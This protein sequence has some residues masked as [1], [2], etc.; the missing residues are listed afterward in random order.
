MMTRILTISCILLAIATFAA[1]TINHDVTVQSTAPQLI[2]P[3]DEFMVRVSI[4]KGALKKGAVLQQ[5]IPD[6]LSASEIESEGA[7][8]YFENQMVRFVW[9]NIPTKSML[10]VSYK[11]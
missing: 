3:G 7:Q 5:I 6:G 2:N 8:F 10:V 11:L 9:D 1:M 4:D